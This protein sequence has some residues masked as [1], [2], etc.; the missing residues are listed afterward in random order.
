MGL[1][2]LADQAKNIDLNEAS[3]N[4]LTENLKRLFDCEAATLFAY[5][6]ARRQ[7][8]SR[9]FRSQGVMEIRLDI[10]LNNLAG[11]VAATGKPLKIKNVH[12]K[13]ELSRYHPNLSYDS[14]W[15]ER[16][17]FTT[18]SIM[19]L[20]LPH[21]NKLVGV[22]EIIN[23]KEA[24]AFSENDFMK[25]Q[26]IAPMMG[27]AL[28]KLA[29]KESLNGRALKKQIDREEQLHR[30]SH[31]VHSAQT[32]EEIQVAL[33]PVLHDLFDCE[34]ANVFSADTEREELVTKLSKDRD[35]QEVRVPISHQNLPG[36]VGAEQRLLNIVNVNH[37]E[38]LKK[39]HPELEFDPVWN[40][41]NETR[42][43]SLLLLP[44]VHKHKLMG[45]LQLVNKRSEE[46]FS[47]LDENNAFLVAETLA[48]GFLN[49]EKFSS[50]PTTKFS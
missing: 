33:P 10:S 32:I 6:S 49:Q 50:P 39:H 38:E 42:T 21:K 40:D 17:N 48:L 8:H 1:E 30:I 2:S 36:F 24:E 25:A 26:A 28:A 34:A 19:V 22:M 29:E 5:D 9:N 35:L 20:P 41:Y 47:G 4:S 44:L 14:G 37:R 23:K 7:L 12:S 3:L 45:V 43:R 27:L 31:T 15:D 18:R 16:L 13:N 46:G 11:Y